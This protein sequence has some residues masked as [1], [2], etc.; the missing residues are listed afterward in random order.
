MTSLSNSDNTSFPI[1]P[2]LNSSLERLIAH[3]R[4][5]GSCIAMYLWGS[6]AAGTADRFSDIDVAAV[7]RDEDYQA[8]RNGLRS[9]CDLLC[10]PTLVWLP[11]GERP[12]SGN[13]AFLFAANEKHYLYDFT[14]MRASA[15][16]KNKD[17]S[18]YRFL[19]DKIG[20]A[21][22]AERPLPPQF[23]AHTIS[24]IIDKYWVYAYLNGKYGRRQ[25]I[26]KMLYVQSVLFQTHVRLLN[27]LH[28]DEVWNWWARDVAHLDEKH[29]GGLL[30]YFGARSTDDIRRILTIEFDLFSRDAKE[31]CVKWGITYPEALENGVRDH[32]SVMLDHR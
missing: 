29:R 14:I 16:Q 1:D 25:D 9:V 5:D 18:S 3:Y 11:E 27:A 19:F 15:F 20:I 23:E 30:V 13:Y 6:L 12:D 7:F 22:N 8:A 26:F 10:G 24:G 28:P 17:R 32:I 31:A 21:N 4:D 2:V